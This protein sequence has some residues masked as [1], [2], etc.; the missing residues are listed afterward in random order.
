LIN[1]GTEQDEMKNFAII[2][3]STKE[4]SRECASRII[5]ILERNGCRCTACLLSDETPDPDKEYLFTDPERVPKE[6]EA[7]LSLGGDGTF[8]H[9]SKD[10]IGL[11][12]PVFGLNFGTLGYLT[13]VGVTEFESALH[14]ILDGDYTVEKRMLLRCEIIKNGKLVRTNLALND[15]VIN[16]SLFIGIAGFDVMVDGHFLNHYSADGMILSTPTG[17]TGYNLSAG[18]PVVLPTSEIV[19]ATPICAHTLNSRT[20][21]FPADVAIEIICRESSRDKTHKSFVTVD[22]EKPIELAEGDIVRTF[23]AEDTAQIIKTNKTSFIETLG[24]KMR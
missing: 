17:S 18:G 11:Q 15:I 24:R 6:T 23:R 13:E 2:A 3:N 7:I 21:V 22:G 5:D 9:V 4:N 19:L 1:N 16:R 14:F 8:I 12:L 10:L 20:I